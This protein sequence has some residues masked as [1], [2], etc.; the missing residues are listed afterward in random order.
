MALCALPQYDIDKHHDEHDVEDYGIHHGVESHDGLHL[1]F[2]NTVEVPAL[3]A[4]TLA[5]A[6]LVHLP[7]FRFCVGGGLLLFSDR[8]W[9]C[10]MLL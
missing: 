6:R 8:S 2:Y 5:W 1:G 3:A 7:C 9:H 4:L 10:R